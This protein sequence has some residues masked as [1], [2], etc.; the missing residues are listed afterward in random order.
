MKPEQQAIAA[1][2]D[3]EEG[4]KCCEGEARGDYLRNRLWLAFTSGMDAGK[5][6][7][8]EEALARLRKLIEG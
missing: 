3:S 1:W 8:R 5:I 6:I 4:Q 2:F 7:G